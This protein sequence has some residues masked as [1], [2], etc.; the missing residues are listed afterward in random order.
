MKIAIVTDHSIW[1][2][3]CVKCYLSADNPGVRVFGKVLCL[4]CIERMRDA[5]IAQAQEDKA[6]DR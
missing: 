5:L 3:N 1:C 4:A 6:R 2:A